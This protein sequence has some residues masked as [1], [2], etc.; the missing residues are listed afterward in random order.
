M[1]VASLILATYC[2]TLVLMQ[3]EG[4]YG[5]VARFRENKKVEELGILNCFLCTSFWIA[6]FISVATN[7]GWFFLAWGGATLIDK[8]VNR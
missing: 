4:P 2:L 3:S 8:V 6:F 5:I 1:E 7:V